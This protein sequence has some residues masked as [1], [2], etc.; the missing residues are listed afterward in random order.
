MLSARTQALT[1]FLEASESG[2][3]E[4]DH[5]LIRQVTCYFFANFWLALYF[6]GQ[7]CVIS[8][9]CVLISRD[10]IGLF[11]CLLRPPDCQP[12]P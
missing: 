11:V 6:E 1:Q 12:L 3:V 4:V 7:S 8:S 9:T 5:H 10:F 2:A